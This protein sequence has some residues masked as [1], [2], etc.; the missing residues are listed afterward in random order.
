MA[1]YGGSYRGVKAKLAEEFGCVGIVL[2]SESA[3]DGSERGPSWPEGPWKN[4]EHCQRGSILPISNTPGDPSTPGWPSPAPGVEARR[5]D[6]T[7]RDAALPKILATPIPMREARLVLQHLEGA[8]PGPV[9]IEIAVEQPRELRPIVNVIAR[10]RGTNDGLVIAGNHRDAWVRGAH[11]AGSGTVALLRAAQQLGERAQNGWQ[12]QNDLML[13]FWDAEETGLVG[14]TEWVE[15]HAEML[16]EHLIAYVNADAAVSGPNFG[17]AAG[18]PGLEASLSRALALV[19]ADEHANQLQRLRALTG[20]DPSMHI[21]GS[22]SDYTA[23]LHHLCLPVLDFSFGGNSGGQYHTRFDDF[24]VVDRFL[25]PGFVGHERAGVF[26]AELLTILSQAGDQAFDE[27][28]FCERFA[29]MTRE[30]A[31]LGGSNALLLADAFESLAEAL[32]ESQAGCRGRLLA[33][34]ALT[35]GLPD[36][37]WFKNALWAPGLETGYAPEFLPLLA[38]AAQLGDAALNDAT[39]ALVAN[40]NSLEARLRTGEFERD[41]RVPAKR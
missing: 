39:R 22:G 11:D 12:P 35:A 26:V 16:N 27:A 33:E 30:A 3:E 41:S 2:F 5:L 28:F 1:R 8:G 7:Q 20:R 18:S 9:R 40:L 29:S 15:A 36:R 21:A 19:P 17:Y 13:A 32:R 14:S 25:D 31:W 10:L 24:A 4:E 34:L 37:P 6:A 23:F 38:D